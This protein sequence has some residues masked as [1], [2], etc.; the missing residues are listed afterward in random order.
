MR[1][2][3]EL[4]GAHGVTSGCGSATGVAAARA[5]TSAASASAVSAT[6]SSCSAGASTG[7]PEAK[8]TKPLL[9]GPKKD[10]VRNMRCFLVDGFGVAI[11]RGAGGILEK[12]P[13]S[14]ALACVRKTTRLGGPATARGF[15]HEG[16]LQ[17]RI[18]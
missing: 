7:A 6:T 1:I 3:A 10:E 13:A 14:R 17:R 8:G 4:A 12:S 18:Q 9:S 11:V 2:R 5:T 16:L 15:G